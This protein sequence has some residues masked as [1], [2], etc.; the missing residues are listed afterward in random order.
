[1]FVFL[2]IY[3]GPTYHVL[4]ARLFIHKEP[5]LYVFV[6]SSI[7]SIAFRFIDLFALLSTLSLDPTVFAESQKVSRQPR[8]APAVDNTPR[9]FTVSTAQP[10]HQN[11]TFDQPPNMADQ[12]NMNGLSLN[13]G[14]G[15]QRSY[16]PPHMRAKMG[17]GPVPG[18]PPAGG[19]PALNGGINS[20][21]W[22][23][24]A[25]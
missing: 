13:G 14:P 19:P 12:L 9:S 21:A 4:P 25:T 17:A 8:L 2:R 1:L 22:A 3:A 7:V 11:L 16:I 10:T 23:A 20:S 6:L 24:P 15:E 5:G 18:G